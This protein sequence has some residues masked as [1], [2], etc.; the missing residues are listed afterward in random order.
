MGLSVFVVLSL[1]VARR[2]MLPVRKHGVAPGK[3]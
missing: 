2:E 1:A 3:A